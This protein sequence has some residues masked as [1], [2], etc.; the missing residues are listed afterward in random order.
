MRHI[1][2]FITVSVLLTAQVLCVHA[3]TATTEDGRK[4]I[5]NADGTWKYAPVEKQGWGGMG[6]EWKKPDNAK[7]VLKGKA[8]FYELWYD[9]AK[10]TLNPNPQNP[11]VEYGLISSSKD[12]QATVIA[13]RTAMPLD[14]L[15]RAAIENAKRA[16]SDLQ[17]VDEQKIVVNGES[18]LKMKMSG[19]IQGIAFAYYGLY[20]AGN[21]GAL[22]II[23]FT[24]QNL[25]AEFQSEFEELLSG[26]VI[27]RP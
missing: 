1:F 2:I 20:W 12:G 4:V 7:S 9:P 15:K 24:S 19:T 8:G 23:T 5:L 6:N 22:Q 26:L 16:S 21:A 14:T 13:E 18:V 11:V 25:A 17:V 10:W 27:T 3:L